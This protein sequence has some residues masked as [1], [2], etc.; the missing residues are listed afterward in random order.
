[1]NTECKINRSQAAFL[2]ACLALITSG[3]GCNSGGGEGVVDTPRVEGW[4]QRRAAGVSVDRATDAAKMS[5]QQWFG[6]VNVQP[7]SPMLVQGG[8]SEYSQ[9]GGGDRIRD[10]VGFNNRLRRTAT[11]QIRPMDDG[12]QIQCVVERQR[13]DTA[14]H[15]VL[16]ENRGGSDVPNATPIERDAGLTRDQQ[17]SWTDLPRDRDMERTILN[18]ILARLR[19]GDGA[20][21]TAEEAS[22]R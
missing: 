10:T 7:G 12:C 1:M 18:S 16:Q 22:D 3:A 19:A 15:R 21:V 9:K 13:L 20:S 4:S 6:R 17:D 8:P 11:V 2:S 14:D 5:L